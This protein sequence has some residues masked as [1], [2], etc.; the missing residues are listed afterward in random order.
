MII[1][2]VLVSAQSGGTFTITKPVIAG[3]VGVNYGA[4]SS[5]RWKSSIEP[6]GQPLDKLARLRGVYFNWDAAHG[7]G[8]DLGMIAEDV[9]K[10]EPLLVTHNHKGEIQGVKYDQIGVVLVNAVKEQQEE[11]SSQRSV[12]SGQQKQIEDQSSK[13]KAQQKQIDTLTRLVCASNKD[14]DICKEQ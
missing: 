9:A 10:V 6:I 5:R 8:H 14:A 4:A 11:I 7:G 3:G 2:A 1:L 12:I 13:I